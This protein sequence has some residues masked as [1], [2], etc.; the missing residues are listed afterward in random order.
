M[1]IDKFKAFIFINALVNINIY[2]I[3]TWQSIILVINIL[4]IKGA[5]L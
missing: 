4:Y 2:Q 3:F 1:P 5:M